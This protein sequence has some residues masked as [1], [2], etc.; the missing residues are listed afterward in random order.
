[1]SSLL[2]IPSIDIRDG[3]TV[4]VVQGIP[5]LNCPEYCNDP[6]EMAMIWRAENAK[7][8][9]VVDFNSAS[10]HS[11]VNFNIIRKICE[12]VI[13]PVEFGAGLRT[14]EDVHE[15]FS[16]GV[17]RVVLGTMAYE[18]PK[19]FVKL[20]EEF[21]PNKIVAAIDVIDN[22]VVVYG[23]K[24]KTGLKPEEFAAK[25]KEYG[26]KRFIVT[27]VKT[28]GMLSG[29]NIELSKR[30]AE[31]SECKVTHSGGIGG[32]HDL[33]RLQNEA[34]DYVDSVIIGRALYENKFPCQKIW[35]VAEHG[36]FQ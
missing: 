2:V 15:A 7:I 23:R 27:D 12:S 32:Y 19:L 21:S 20:L 28:N 35:R 13:I 4:R 6:V 10:E 5:E 11:H 3:K 22:Q 17:F 30:I 29:P 33:I 9:H 36:I 34:K 25:L 18:N 31:V 8:I 16:L 14:M 26:V 1:M 24:Y